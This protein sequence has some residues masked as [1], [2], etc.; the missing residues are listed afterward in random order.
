MN[1]NQLDLDFVRA[2]FP[3]LDTPWALFDNAGGSVPCRQ[4]IERVTDYMGRHQ[5]QLGATYEHSAEA[6]AAVQDGRVAVARMM[7]AAPDE[8]VLG[9][10][11]TQLAALLARALRGTWED[12][13]EVVVTTL[14]HET[15]VGPWASL[16]AQGIEVREWRMRSE[17]A[18]LELED[19]EPHLSP[20][21]RLVAFTACSNITG[22][23]PDAKAII[24]RIHAAGALACIDAVA[25]APHRRVD[26]AALDADF[27]FFSLYKVFGPHQSALFGKRELL[28]HARSQ[29]HFFFDETD[30]PDKLEPGGVNHELVASLPGILDYVDAVHRHHGGD[31]SATSDERLA[32]VFERFAAH[33]A[34]LAAPLLSYLAERDDVRVIGAP[35]ADPTRRVPTISFVVR[36]VDASTIPPAL[37]AR[38]V[39]VRFGHFYAR[40]AIEQLGL[41][42]RNGVVRVSLLHYNTPEEVERLLAGLDEVLPR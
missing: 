33:E 31:E 32:Q 27:C 16:R 7:N 30:V 38:Q 13:D 24:E 14:D 18:T 3:A 20:R 29:N 22:T 11:S 28:E 6:A 21:T 41:L 39:A 35:S 4:V 2:Q 9:A 42:E 25:F 26:V 5:V 36:D 34:Q 19:L 1:A 23:F 8:I 15:N 37:D 10:S 12:R 17:T 40:R